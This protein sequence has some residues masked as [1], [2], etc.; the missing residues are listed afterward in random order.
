MR[1]GG[2]SARRGRGGVGVAR[3]CRGGKGECNCGGWV[4]SESVREQE[5]GVQETN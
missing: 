2:K 3:G 4:V 5:S 1:G